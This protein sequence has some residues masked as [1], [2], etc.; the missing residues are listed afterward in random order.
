MVD[1]D[2]VGHG[3]YSMEL[4]SLARFFLRLLIIDLLPGLRCHQI[5]LVFQLALH[6]IIPTIPHLSLLF[7]L[8]ALDLYGADCRMP[9]TSS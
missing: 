8:H 1:S 9:A 4:H 3:L 2:V 5:H 7:D 6:H